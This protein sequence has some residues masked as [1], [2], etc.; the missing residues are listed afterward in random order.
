M[1]E[2]EME[3]LI[4]K[5]NIFDKT[6]DKIRLIDPV[7]RKIL[8][9]KDNHLIDSGIDC[10]QFW[11]KNTV[12]DNCIAMRAYRENDTFIKIEYAKDDIYMLTAIP[13]EYKGR[14]VVAE[15]LKKATNSITFGSDQMEMNAD[16][17]RMIDN[18]NTVALKDSLTGIYNRRY[19]NERLPVDILNEELAGQKLSVIMADLDLF[20]NV[21]DTYGHLIGDC[22]LKSFA[23]I[24]QQ[25]LKR[26]NDWVARYG[27]EEFLICMPGAGLELAMQTAERMRKALEESE[28]DCGG[29]HFKI[30]AS[31]GVFSMVPSSDT[32]ME[33]L[34]ENSDKM[35]YTAKRNGR[36]KV[37][38]YSV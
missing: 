34:I 33:E 12:C 7:E 31:F 6:F 14:M 11:G 30:T 13:L 37:E 28:M 38:G 21:N 19:I 15:L 36:N 32:A 24:L 18:L 5:L 1:Y 22:T 2:R 8:E 20:K 4:S 35:L 23:R 9:I 26:E 16:I 10:F 27:G 17:H 29:F 3:E 25:E